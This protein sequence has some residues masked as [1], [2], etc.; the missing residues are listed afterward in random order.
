MDCL[1][2]TD[3]ILKHGQ[4]P[5]FRNV[6]LLSKEMILAP[7]VTRQHWQMFVVYPK[8]YEIVYI[9]LM[10][11]DTS[12]Q[13][14][15]AVLSTWQRILSRCKM[16]L[17]NKD[18]LQKRWKL[19]TVKHQL[20]QDSTSCGIYVMKFDFLLDGENM[21]TPFDTVETRIHTASHLIQLRPEY[22]QHPI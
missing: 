11:E 5:V 1:A 20:Q 15:E 8:N 16:G 18:T 22:T 7:Y 6:D 4:P 21:S 19:T 12:H 3:V 10:G 9:N 13:S 14:K 2:A 17:L